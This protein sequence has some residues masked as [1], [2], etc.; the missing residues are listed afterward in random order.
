MSSEPSENTPTTLN[1]IVNY[2][3]NTSAQNVNGNNII[4]NE[5]SSRITNTNTF[6]TR[7]VLGGYGLGLAA[8]LVDLLV[9][10]I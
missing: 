1:Y 8:C 7:W 9:R 4:G 3:V 5:T 2:T 6:N 10:H